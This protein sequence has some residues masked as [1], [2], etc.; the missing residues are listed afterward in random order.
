MATIKEVAKLAG[1]SV[2][3]VSNVLNG[4]TSND[5][6]L[7]RVENAINQLSYRPDANARSLK[8]T[9][10]KLIGVIMPEVCQSDHAHF[11]SSLENFLREKGYGLILKISN[12]N[13]LLEKKSLMQCVEQCVDGIIWYSP[14]KA[15][16]HSGREKR[17]SICD[18][19]EISIIWVYRRS[20]P[21]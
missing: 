19:Y 16:Y 12:N 9:K 1:V 4:K 21:D 15:A 6:L 14:A 17:N 8:N 11:L 13:W 20:D 5:E 10:S 2:G 18:Y 7:E 3:T